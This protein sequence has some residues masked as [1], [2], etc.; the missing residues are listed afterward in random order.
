MLMS[1]ECCDLATAHAWVATVG[2]VG[3]AAGSE[4]GSPRDW[5]FADLERYWMNGLEMN[6]FQVEILSVP[7]ARHH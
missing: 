1:G 5:E 3:E 7:S 2:N 4:F 6:D